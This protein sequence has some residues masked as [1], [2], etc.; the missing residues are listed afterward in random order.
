MAS[1]AIPVWTWRDAIRKADV[2]PMTKLICHSIANYVADVGKGSY[3]SVK[4]LM[5]DSGMSNRSVAT[6]LQ[7]AVDAGL[8]EIERDRGKDGRIARTTYYP[9]FPDNTVLKRRA[10][11]FEEPVD[12]EEFEEDQVKEAHL[13]KPSEGASLGDDIHVKEVHVD[14]PSEGASRGPRELGALHHVKEVHGELSIRE[15]STHTPNP[16]PSGEAR[17]RVREVWIDELMEDG[18]ASHVVT[19]YIERLHGSL[20]APGGSINLQALMRA[21]RDALADFDEVVLERAAV[22]TLRSRTVWPSASQAAAFATQA[23]R[24][25][26]KPKFYPDHPAF[27]SWIAHY[28]AIGKDFW[29]REC[30]SRG[31]VQERSAVPPISKGTAA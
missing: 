13:A 7:L 28:R 9:R 3:P 12:D 4:Q 31:F 19:S 1:Q 20:K 24:E 18:R 22:L 17:Q 25:L 15:L 27:K 2:A 23:D 21:I 6:H 30:T 26:P 29:A 16:S 14:R 11:R 10:D 5:A 8:L